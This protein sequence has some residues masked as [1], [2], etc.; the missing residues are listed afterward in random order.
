[1]PAIVFIDI[2]GELKE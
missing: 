1:M 2:T